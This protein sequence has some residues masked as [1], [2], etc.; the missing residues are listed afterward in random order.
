MPE[1]RSAPPARAAVG[2]APVPDDPAPVSAD[3]EPPARRR[4]PLLVAA[5]VLLAVLVATGVWLSGRGP[6]TS[7]GRQPDPPAAATPNNP[8]AGSSAPDGTAAP[9]GGAAPAGG[10][11]PPSAAPKSAAPAPSGNGNGTGAGGSVPQRPPLPAGWTLYRDRTG[12]SLYVP[13]GWKRS[14]E[15][16]MVYFRDGRGRV[17][18]I[19]QS[20]RPKSDP[21]ADWR[22]QAEYRVGRGDFP[23]YREVRIVPVRYW[24]KAADWEFTFNGS[25]GARQHVNNRGFVVSARQAYGIYFQTGDAAWADSG[26]IRKMIF[27]SFRPDE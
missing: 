16:R 5:V 24:Q 1:R 3:D 4:R 14:Q 7:A 11:A 25:G 26:D 6:D 2:A 12:F 10:S 21:V 17:L 13:D 23:G 8:T 15:G 27:D 20:D 18:G 22:S 9:T 19:D